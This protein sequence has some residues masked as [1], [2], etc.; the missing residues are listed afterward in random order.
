MTTGDKSTLH[1]ESTQRSKVDEDWLCLI[2]I[3]SNK[4]QF[5]LRP[6]FFAYKDR[7]NIVHLIVETY[8]SLLLTLSVDEQVTTPQELWV[9][10][11][12]IMTDSK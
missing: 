6:L 3:F 9:K 11:T 1:F 7:E 5:S 4:Q 8:E 2:L 12:A 10:T